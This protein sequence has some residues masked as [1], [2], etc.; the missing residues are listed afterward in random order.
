[1]CYVP[2]ILNIYIKNIFGVLFLLLLFG[3][4]VQDGKS[5]PDNNSLT[6]IDGICYYNFDRM[7]EH[8]SQDLIKIFK[9]NN[10]TIL[11]E[12]LKNKELYFYYSQNKKTNRCPNGSEDEKIVVSI[13]V[14]DTNYLGGILRL[15]YSNDKLVAVEYSATIQK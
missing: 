3:C 11:I 15:Y 13:D 7:N 2:M 1:M 4:S 10:Q 6:D 12:Y 9:N 8:V 14:D 5:L